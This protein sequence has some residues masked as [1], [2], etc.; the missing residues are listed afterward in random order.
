MISV[1][2][3]ENLSSHNE[4]MTCSLTHYTLSFI[5]DLVAYTL[6]FISRSLFKAACSACESLS[7]SLHVVSLPNIPN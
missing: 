3:D 6:S 1:I 7:L 4:K 2:H 5:D